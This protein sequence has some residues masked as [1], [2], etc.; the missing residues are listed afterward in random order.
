MQYSVQQHRPQV[1]DAI[2]T[3]SPECFLAARVSDEVSLAALTCRHNP[4]WH[5]ARLRGLPLRFAQSRAST[6]GTPKLSWKSCCRL[7]HFQSR[8]LSRAVDLTCPDC[9]RK[10]YLRRTNSYGAAEAAATDISERPHVNKPS[11]CDRENRSYS[12]TP[13]H[14]HN[15]I[16][17]GSM[18]AR[19][20]CLA[21]SSASKTALILA[22]PSLISSARSSSCDGARAG[23]DDELDGRGAMRR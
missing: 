20:L 10:C 8:E 19:C 9:G 15:N 14:T 13:Y 23:V 5:D 6:L 1:P 7:S 17:S 2:P 18:A 21:R 3:F 16:S 11:R 4:A 22:C 12:S